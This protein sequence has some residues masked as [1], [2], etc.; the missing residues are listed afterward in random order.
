MVDIRVNRRKF[1]IGAA[2]LPV[3]AAPDLS[4]ANIPGEQRLVV[5]VL[6]G[7]MDGMSAVAPVGDPDYYALRP[8]IAIPKP[9]ETNGALPLGPFFGLHPSLKPIYP[10]W[11][12]GQLLPIHAVG[13]P[14]GTRSHFDAQ[15]ILENGTGKANGA[16]DGWLNRAI[17]ELG[18]SSEEGLSIGQ[19][20]PLILRGDVIVQTWSPSGLPVAE[21]DFLDKVSV[22]YRDDP[23]FRET[24]GSARKSAEISSMTMGRNDKKKKN[25]GKQ[26]AALCRSAGALLAV[27]NGPRIATIEATGWDT[28][29]N[30]NGKLSRSFGQLATGVDNLRQSLGDYWDNTVVLMVSEFGRTARENGGRGTD[31]GSANAVLLC[32]GAV[33]GGR[34]AATWPGLSDQS[35]YEKRDLFPTTDIRSVF[36]GVL[37][38]HLGIPEPILSRQIFPQSAAAT[39]LNNLVRVSVRL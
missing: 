28:H 15:D 33:K 38:D 21:D 3:L 4:F 11:E 27:K 23:F 24:L 25:K 12:K 9:G 39:P 14:K 7:G 2:S 18:G 16:R 8:N 6:R 26:F 35:L 36:K 22:L 20:V 17:L 31:H 1:M 13:S 5:M 10:L 19:A 30:Q 29:T 34:V 37:R 32:G